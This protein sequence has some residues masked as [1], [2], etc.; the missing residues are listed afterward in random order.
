[1]KQPVVVIGAG[2][3]ARALI[4]LLET[5]GFSV[6]GVYDD[7]FEPNNN[8]LISGYRLM[9]RVADAALV[10]EAKVAIAVGEN[11]LRAKLSQMFVDRFLVDNLIHPDSRVEGRVRLGKG[12]QIFANAYVNAGAGIGDN[13]IINTGAIIEHEAQV[14][15]HCHIS[16]RAVLCGRVSVGDRSFIGAGAVIIDGV[17]VCDDVTVGAGGVVIRD[18]VEPGT[19]VGH[20]VR[21]VK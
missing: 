21:R 2:G 13:N 19:Y 20:P 6:L 5:A 15:S 16:V 17:S 9:G 11:V 8:E 10:Q 14:G 4:M 3:H 1:M 18:I 7:S 12:N